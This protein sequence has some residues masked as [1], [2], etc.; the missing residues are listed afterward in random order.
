M[1]RPCWG[2][3]LA[4]SYKNATWDWCQGSRLMF[5][6]Y[7]G[8][9]FQP[10]LWGRDIT[11]QGTKHCAHREHRIVLVT[12][13]C[14]LFWSSYSRLLSFLLNPLSWSNPV[15]PSATKVISME[16]FFN[17]RETY[18]SSIFLSRGFR[19]GFA[20]G[21]SVGQR[22]LWRRVAV[23]ERICLNFTQYKWKDL[24]DV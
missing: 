14:L 1:Q 17:H 24:W 21:Y 4:V 20:G 19:G 6:S 3:C 12:W 15:R 13:Q 5:V 23:I 18:T 9:W 10:W 2:R 11:E 8:P 16:I 22:L 7:F